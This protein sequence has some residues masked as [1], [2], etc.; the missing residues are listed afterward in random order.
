M[1]FSRLEHLFFLIAEFSQRQHPCDEGPPDITNMADTAG[2]VIGRLL[3]SGAHPIY[4][5]GLGMV[6]TFHHVILIS[7][8]KV[9]TG[10]QLYT[11]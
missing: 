3:F 2:H 10:Q 6:S 9:D 7:V 1:V 4:I 8:A 11:G 5:A